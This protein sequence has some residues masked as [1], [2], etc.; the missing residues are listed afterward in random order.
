MATSARTVY[1]H[2]AAAVITSSLVVSGLLHAK[3]QRERRQQL[4]MALQELGAEAERL[5]VMADA[6]RL[7]QDILRLS[8]TRGVDVADF[9]D[10]QIDVNNAALPRDR[11]NQILHEAL[12]GGA[13][14]VSIESF[15]VETGHPQDGLFNEFQAS[16]SQLP[17]LTLKGRQYFKKTAP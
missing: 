17:V 9:S 8:R 3:H 16:S 10:R 11:I 2:L 12:S 5:K 1:L 4:D 14:F 7:D 13:G 15:R 6:V